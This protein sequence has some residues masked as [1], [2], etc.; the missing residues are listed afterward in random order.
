[1]KNKAAQ[2]FVLCM[3]LGLALCLPAPVSAGQKRCPPSKIIKSKA[4]LE[5]VQA[6]LNKLSPITLAPD[7][8]YLPVTEQAV[9]A[10]LIKAAKS[11]DRIFLRQVSAK[12][13]RLLKA[14]ECYK[15]TPRQPYYDYFKIMYGPW[16]RLNANVPFI[17]LDEPKPA[18][19]NYYP[20]DMS[21]EEF[22]AWLDAH[23]EQEESFISPFTVIKRKGQNLKAV[24]YNREY[25]DLLV[26]PAFYL[27]KAAS[28]TSDPTLAAYLKS[29]AKALFTNDYRQSDINWI[30]LN[31]DIELVIGP[32]ETYEDELMGYKAAFETFVCLVDR[33]ESEKLKTIE[34]YRQDM[35]DNYPL[36]EGV[37][38]TPKGLASPI[39]VVNEVFS[40][41]DARVGIPAIAFNL[42]NDEWVREN[43]GSKNVMIK[44][45]LE[46]KYNGVL[47]PIKDRILSAADKD[48]PSFD[49]FFNYVLMH[50]IS[51]GLGPGAILVNGQETTV[52]EQLKE[53]YSMIEECQADTLSMVNCQYLIDTPDGPMPEG[54]Q[55]ALYASYL[56]GM[57]RS[58][59]FGTETA[60]GG[61]IT[62]ELNWHI[63]N[64]GFNVDADGR[65][66]L[67]TE[68]LKASVRSL[69]ERLL[70]IELNGDYAG[71]QAL[72]DQYNSIKPEVQAA[73]DMI[74]DVPTDVIK[75]YP[76]DA[77]VGMRFVDEQ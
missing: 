30:G 40:A 57:F 15:G 45:M 13:H 2:R 51:H 18:G 9:I 70:S 10:D 49:G 19:A 73:L 6:Q 46:A 27:R 29:R 63:E 7:Y 75:K 36:P 25:R 14:L 64:G 60:H 62:I 48:K 53:L 12:N 26:Q 52:R 1:M 39:K 47:V 66:Y 74:Q 3:L 58:I 8:S 11:V 76:F 31:G 37:E 28:K 56:A 22:E 24:P 17:N 34:E 43:V 65:F 55:D 72:I 42:P 5:E 67:D 71:A 61:A 35:I 38:L 33:D 16:D 50:E 32:Y 21:T 77:H 69:A 44:N 20:A 54:L 23:P 59:R 41:G 4:P 68:K